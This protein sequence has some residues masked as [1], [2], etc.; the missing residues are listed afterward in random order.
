MTY[1]RV[2]GIALIVIIV[3]GVSGYYGYR[4][5]VEKPPTSLIKFLTATK[6][7]QPLPAGDIAPLVVPEGFVATI[8]SRDVSGARVMTR[9]PK[10]T[11]L[12]SETNGGKVVALPDLNADRKADKTVTILEGLNEPHGIAVICPNTGNVSADQDACRL[13]VA[14]TG[15]LKS[16]AYDADTMT[17]AN[18]I[19]L[20][21][22][23]TGEGHFTR[24]ILPTADGRSLFVSIGSDCNVC[25]ETNPLRATIQVFDLASNSMTTFATGL[26]NSV[27]MALNPIS[28][29]LWAT[30]N[31]RDV[32]GDDIPPDDVNIVKKDG[33]Y[34]WP[35]CYGQNIH[36]TDF[37]TKQYF[38]DP[39][40]DDIP[41]HIEL[42]AHS[43]ALGLSFIPEEG[44]PT[45]WGNDLL[46]AF[47][48]SWNRSVPTGY[49]VVRI[50]LDDKGNPIAP[51]QDFVTG[52]LPAGAKDTSDAIGR[53]VGVMAE[54]GGVVYISDD[55]A[56]AIYRIALTKEAR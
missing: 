18:P 5:I 33:N 35:I 25:V 50:D 7:S 6:P 42:P 9:D 11:M 2:V 43:A 30:D 53:P 20:A 40:A 29:E 12:V 36:D 47:H 54:P 3:L 34:G 10:G 21:A 41:S 17:A 19:E 23:P 13:Y 55:R 49:K 39:C 32:L 15:S 56:G 31:G 24:T 37:D 16:Y 45:G 51:I 8:F 48:G 38:R 44:W 26:R 4:Y 1:V 28:G 14:E 52:F 22:F 27:F 46:V